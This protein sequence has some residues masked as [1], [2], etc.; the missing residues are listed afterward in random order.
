VPFTLRPWKGGVLME[1]MT[2]V[3]GHVLNHAGNRM[4]AQLA[5]KKMDHEAQLA[6]MSG[7]LAM[8]RM[9]HA[10]EMFDLRANLVRDVLKALVES[11]V[12]AVKS[13]FETIM[14]EF[15]K[16]ADRYLAQQDHF[17]NAQI[18][19]NDPLEAARCHARL[20]EIDSQLSKIRTD[21]QKLFR[22]MNRT[23]LAI[24]GGP[25]PIPVADRRALGM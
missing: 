15:G 18:T 20:S 11:R 6:A 22:E 1:P 13:G 2:V 5:L 17:A 10:Q 24:G 14:K 12:D 16:Q 8:R 21:C 9:D 19:M 3:L 4:Q 23:L 25:I 7:T